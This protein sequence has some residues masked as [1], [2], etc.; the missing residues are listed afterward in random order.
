MNNVPDTT[1]WRLLGTDH[2]HHL[3]QKRDP[4]TK[5]SL[6][7]PNHLQKPYW[8]C[9]KW[10]KSPDNCWTIRWVMSL[11]QLHDVFLG[12]DHMHHVNQRRDPS[13]KISLQKPN[14]LQKPYWKCSIGGKWQKSPDNGWTIRWVMSLTQLYDV[15]LGI[16]HMYDANTNFGLG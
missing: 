2:M 10:Q 5:I 15:F 12:I 1:S 16:D 8:K 14:L 9:W 4:S 11:T 7:K 3:N 6:Q 13:M